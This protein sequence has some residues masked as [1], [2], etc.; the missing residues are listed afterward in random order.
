MTKS[1]TETPES[2]TSPVGHTVTISANRRAYFTEYLSACP[3]K[4]RCTRSELRR[5]M[6]VYPYHSYAKAKRKRLRAE[7]T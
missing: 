1:T 5:V 3:S 6:N 7:G 2:A 4:N